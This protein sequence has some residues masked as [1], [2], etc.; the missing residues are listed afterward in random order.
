[1]Y[2]VHLEALKLGLQGSDRSSRALPFAQKLGGVIAGFIG[3]G[4]LGVLTHLLFGW[5]QDVFPAA[6]IPAAITIFL[7]I[8]LA[9]LKVAAESQDLG[10]LLAD[11][12]SIRDIPAREILVQGLHFLVP[13]VVLLWCV[14]IER[15]SPALSAF[16]G[17]MAILFV[18]LTQE[19]LKNYFRGQ[20]WTAHWSLGFRAALS[21]DPRC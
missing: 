3:F 12:P 4:L 14:L 6:T 21:D 11:D 19:P 13:I 2:I 1:M 5:T 9:T 7:L 16:W 8:Y 15:L 17:T 18:I 10:D 20:A